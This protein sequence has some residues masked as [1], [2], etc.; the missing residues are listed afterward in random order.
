M[1]I[2]QIIILSGI[3]SQLIFL[4][5]CEKSKLTTISSQSTITTGIFATTGQIST[6][7][8]TPTKSNTIPTIIPTATKTYVP[9]L[10]TEEA[11]N[12]LYK[13]ISNNDNCRLPCLW[14]IIPGKS[15]VVDTINILLPLRSISRITVFNTNYGGI[16][17]HDQVDTLFYDFRIDYLAEN[18]IISGA[19][20]T[21]EVNTD[22]YPV[23]NS[24]NFGRITAYYSLTNMLAEYG[25]PSSIYIRSTVYSTNPTGGPFDILILFADQGIL[26]N[27][28]TMMRISGSN[29]IGC[30]LNAHIDVNLYPS[31]QGNSFMK[32]IEPEWHER[33]PSYISLEEAS[34]MTIDQFYQTYRIPTD[35]CIISPLGIWPTLESL[36]K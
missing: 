31:G 34:K 22:S 25:K 5:S 29:T 21:A 32:L 3:I 11:R 19:F 17:I 6:K 8:V 27:Y 30:P 16:Q 14:G 35:Q 2:K 24:N 20:L 9:T 10:P 13:L 33:L 7:T 36:G 15:N 1:G 26:V 18:D 4:S 12:K 23:F 28:S